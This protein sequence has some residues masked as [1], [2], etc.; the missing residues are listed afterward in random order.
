MSHPATVHARLTLP[1]L[2]RSVPFLLMM[3]IVFSLDRGPRGESQQMAIDGLL[4]LIGGSLGMNARQLR[5][6][7]FASDLRTLPLGRDHELPT[8]HRLAGFLAL[9]VGLLYA[10]SE[11]TALPERGMAWISERMGLQAIHLV[12]VRPLRGLDVLFATWCA[13]WSTVW[14]HLAAKPRFLQPLGE[15]VWVVVVAALVL[16]FSL[17]RDQVSVEAPLPLAATSAAVLFALGL[18]AARQSLA[19]LANLAPLDAPLEDAA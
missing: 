13:Y 19:R 8:T 15:Q 6:R 10:V 2:A 5:T 9:L 3:T 7:G 4:V 14:L 12:E 11:G 17:L 18:L 16:A 1:R